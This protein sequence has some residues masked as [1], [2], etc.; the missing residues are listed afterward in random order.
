MPTRVSQLP[1]EDQLAYFQRKRELKN[2]RQREYN[3]LKLADPEYRA[4]ANAYKKMV[5]DRDHPLEARR[6]RGRP[7]KVAR[8]PKGPS[9]PPPCPPPS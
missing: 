9:L 7:P 6:P 3:R 2:E 5:Y 4:R 8:T 1:P